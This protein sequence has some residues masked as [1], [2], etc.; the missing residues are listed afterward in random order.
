MPPKG[1]GILTD[2]DHLIFLLTCVRNAEISKARKPTKSLASSSTDI[3][4][5]PDFQKVADE[6]GITSAAAAHKRYYRLLKNTQ[7]GKKGAAVLPATPSR[8]DLDSDNYSQPTPI[9][10]RKTSVKPASNLLR[11]R[12]TDR[13]SEA[14]AADDLTGENEDMDEGEA[15]GEQDD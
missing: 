8:A 15:G 10:K 12:K 6:L 13:D 7:A 3:T 4:R 11:K 14:G 1:Q 9:E 2:A 5:Q